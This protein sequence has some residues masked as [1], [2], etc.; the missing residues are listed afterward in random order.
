MSKAWISLLVE[1][2]WPENFEI[3][4]E[5]NTSFTWKTAYIYYN[6]SLSSHCSEKCF[7]QQF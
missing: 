3:L 2:Y 1:K 7:R 4:T 5:E 6:I